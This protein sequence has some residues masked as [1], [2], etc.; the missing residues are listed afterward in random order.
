MLGA[1]PEKL[2][3]LRSCGRMVTSTDIRGYRGE[4]SAPAGLATVQERLVAFRQ[5]RRHTWSVRALKLMLPAVAAIALLVYGATVFIV[6][7]VRPKNFDPGTMRIDSEHLTMEN[8]KYDGFGNDGTRYQLRAKSAV[9]DIKMSGPIRLNEIDGDLVQQTG[10]VTRVKA[11]WGSFDQ[12]KNE[13]ELYERINIDGSAG[14][15]ARLTR[16][17]VYTKENRVVS[18]EPVAV[19]MPTASVRARTMVLRSKSRQISFKDA[20]EVQLK[21]NPAT[22]AA[23]EPQAAKAKAPSTLPGLALNSSAPVDVRSDLL[24]IDDNARTAV[25]RQNVT[26]QQADAAL[27]APELEVVY[28]GRAALPGGEMQ[29]AAQSATRLKA[30]KARGGVVMT[31]KEERATS[32]TL[33]YEAQSERATLRG[34]VVLSSGSERRVTSAVAEF[35]Q[36][37]DTALLIGG[38]VVNQ[39]QNILRGQRLSVD[40]KAARSRLDS[41]AA[42]GQ[43]AG[44]ISATLYR[45]DQKSTAG[46]APAKDADRAETP[47][48]AAL[49]VPMLGGTFKT[50]PKAPVDVDADTLDV[51]DQSKVA[52]FK[53]SVVAK[54]GAFVIRAAELTARYSGQAGLGLAQAPA[55][56]APKQGTQL[57]KIEARQKVVITSSD[58]RTASGDWADFDVKGNTAIVGGKVVVSQG[59]SVVEGTRLLIDMTTGQSRFEVDEGQAGNAA[60]AQ[61]SPTCPE[62]QVCSKGRVRAVFYPKEIDGAK[63]KKG[64]DPA[65]GSAPPSV[66]KQPSTSSWGSTTSPGAQ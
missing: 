42:E 45:T 50:D 23:R 30:L 38:V 28:E 59:Q 7:G 20:V 26:A 16:A 8:P 48:G 66:A 6:I 15:T 11:N 46:E 61:A 13:L 51:L 34:N 65:A 64:N 9:T 1:N 35:D 49:G 5:A 19:E 14:M 29:A 32:D 53:G 39:G 21:P 52:V 22:Q 43:P 36:L 24:D 33:D 17:T 12:K 2:T 10:A 25:F 60:S 55:P 62:G 37:A 3:A 47:G 54:Q 40:R 27:A 58:G 18:Q 31:Q 44:R 56:G 4:R 41:P 57:T 63:K